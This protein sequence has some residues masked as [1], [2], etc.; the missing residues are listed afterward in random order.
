MSDARNVLAALGRGLRYPDAE[1]LRELRQLFESTDG[2][3]RE[4]A[5]PV[6]AFLGDAGALGSA[7][8]EELYTRTFDVMPACVP[9]V[10]VHAFGEESFLRAALMTGLAD[11]YGRAGIESDGE[12]VDH[13]RV[14]LAASPALPRDEW[15]ELA[16]F[17]LLRAVW[18]MCAS[19]EQGANPYRHL[20]EVV[21]TLLL[22]DL[23]L[24]RAEADALARPV[25]VP[26]APPGYA[27]GCP[28]MD[29][30]RQSTLREE[31]G[32]G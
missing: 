23:G 24:S 25:E 32:I 16:R 14:I 1:T 28:G 26:K 6:K 29:R 19:L 5:E 22:E 9:Y 30:S 17:C 11:T 13:L 4:V 2:A 21:R 7:G 15:Q 12:L 8:M 31:G 3:L 10:S 20:L 18:A 27:H